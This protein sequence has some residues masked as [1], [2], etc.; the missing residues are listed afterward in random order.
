LDHR[1]RRHEGPGGCGA[2][3]ITVAG[4]SSIYA[5]KAAFRPG[6]EAI[7]PDILGLPGRC[8]MMM[9]LADRR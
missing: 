6:I 2:I 3:I 1:N 7:P 8:L 5:E 4:T 9:P